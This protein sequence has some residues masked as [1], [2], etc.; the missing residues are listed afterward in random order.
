MAD[1]TELVSEPTPPP[2][3]PPLVVDDEPE[4]EP[5]DEEAVSNST[6]GVKTCNKAYEISF[7]T[8]CSNGSMHSPEGQCP[9]RSSVSLCWIR[10]QSNIGCRP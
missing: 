1:A 2:I 5:V 7:I 10:E 9:E 8:S 3:I 4:A 6:E